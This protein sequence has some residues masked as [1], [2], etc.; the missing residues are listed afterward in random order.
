LSSSEIACAVDFSASASATADPSIDYLWAYSAYMWAGSNSALYSYHHLLITPDS[1][2]GTT[3]AFPYP[4]WNSPQPSDVTST[5]RQSKSW[6]QT[7]Y[8]AEFTLAIPGANVTL[9]YFLKN[10]QCMIFVP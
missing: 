3:Y 4:E 8:G 1:I 2:G 10:W 9:W 5:R 6:R 7:N